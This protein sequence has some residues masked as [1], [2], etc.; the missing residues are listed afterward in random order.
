MQKRELLERITVDPQVVAGRPRIRGTRLTVRYIVSIMAPGASKDE[1]LSEYPGLTRDDVYACLA[2]AAE[3]LE[4]V[5]AEAAVE[6]AWVR[7]VVD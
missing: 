2:Y 7:L 6:T 4:Q 3:A 5:P 1:V